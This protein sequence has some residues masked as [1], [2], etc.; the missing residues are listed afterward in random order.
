MFKKQIQED[1]DLVDVDS[2][3]EDISSSKPSYS[4]K[5]EGSSMFVETDEEWQLRVQRQ[6]ERTQR[7]M[8][9]FLS[10]PDESMR[11]FFSSHFRDTGMMW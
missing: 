6:A 11:I 4:Q 5:A 2:E 9:A 10:D 3:E 1:E 7:R 8:D